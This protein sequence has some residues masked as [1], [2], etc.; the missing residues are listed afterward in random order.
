MGTGTRLQ[1]PHWPHHV[2]TTMTMFLS[3]RSLLFA[4]GNR[5]F[6]PLHIRAKSR[7]H[8]ILGAQKKSVQRPSQHTSNIV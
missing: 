3:T 5:F 2:P 1:P 4:S 8:E 6:G 7:D